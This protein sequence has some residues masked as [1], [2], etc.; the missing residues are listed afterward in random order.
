M[1]R[2]EKNSVFVVGGDTLTTQMFRDKGFHIVMGDTWREPDFIVFTGGS[3]V[4]PHLYNETKLNR[5][6]TDPRRDAKEEAIF[7]KYIDKPKIGIC[8][9]GQF[10]NV[11]NGGAMWQHVNNHGGH[12]QATDIFLNKGNRFY[13]TSTHH[14]M[15]VPA[16]DGD[17]LTIAS[18]ATEFVSASGRK[19]PE[20]D[21]EVVWYQKTKSLC[22]QPHPEYTSN[23]ADPCR[24]YFFDLIERL[25]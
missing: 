15:M 9:G 11:M 8:R 14:Q 22:Y 4:S 10:L 18:E 19:R 17:V 16:E 13:V 23:P 2:S 20:F 21:T 6:F 24:T 1:P 12:H 5:T 25:F 7:D 3:D